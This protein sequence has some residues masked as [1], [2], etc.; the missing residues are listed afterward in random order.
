MS[1]EA[2]PM[3]E[4]KSLP[5][6]HWS[7]VLAAGRRSAPQAQ[8]ALETLCRLYW[9]PLYAYLRRRLTDPVEAEDVTQAFFT[10]LLDKHYLRTATPARGRFRAF[11]LTACQHFLSKHR[12][13]AKAQKRGGGRKLLSLDFV[14]ADRRLEHLKAVGRTPEQEYER[15]W[16]LTLLATV[17]GQLEH[18][19]LQED[20]KPLFTALRPFLL[21]EHAGLTYAAVAQPL[22]MTEAAVKMAASRLRRRYRELL[23]QQIAQT[24]AGPE[25]VADELR[26]LFTALGR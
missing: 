21:G 2:A 3:P 25:E 6:T 23:R 26:Q 24:V 17:L 11:L 18:E 9:I 19:Y 5:T 13:K 8:Q 22:G 4:S 1:R 7:L 20:K 14:T 15:Q 10:E 16:A 12:A